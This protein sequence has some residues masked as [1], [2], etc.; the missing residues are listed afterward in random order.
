[1]FKRLLKIIILAYIYQLAKFDDFMTCGSKDIL[2]LISCTNTHCDVTDLVNHEM[3]KNTKT[4]ISWE[5]NIIF[6]RNKKFLIYA[7]DGTF[8][9]VIVL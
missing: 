6:L 9:E 3:V 2:H 4:W 1:M 7:L 8:S 5:R